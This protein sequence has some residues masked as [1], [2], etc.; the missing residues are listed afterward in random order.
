MI[1]KKERSCYIY[2]YIHIY[3]YIYIYIYSPE[4]W[5]FVTNRTEILEPL[6]DADSFLLYISEGPLGYLS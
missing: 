5:N 1:I 6:T 4:T 2:I 3:I